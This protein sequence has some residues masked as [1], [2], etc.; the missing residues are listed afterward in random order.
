MMIN[1]IFLP[2]SE[3]GGG[4]VDGEPAEAPQ[5]VGGRHRV[6]RSLVR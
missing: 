6:E 2:G 4:W 3:G 1:T 5:P